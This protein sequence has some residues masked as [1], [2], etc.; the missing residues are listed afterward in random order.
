MRVP[1]GTTCAWGQS[2]QRQPLKDARISLQAFV[3]CLRSHAISCP[4]RFLFREFKGSPKLNNTDLLPQH[5]WH[6]KHYLYWGWY[7]WHQVMNNYIYQ[8][9]TFPSCLLSDLDNYRGSCQTSIN[10]TGKASLCM[11]QTTQAMCS[12]LNR[13]HRIIFPRTILS[14]AYN[15]LSWSNCLESSSV[16]KYCIAVCGKQMN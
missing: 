15:D 9:L 5:H 3:C 16:D 8:E 11:S 13:L 6:L 10:I 4:S 12:T 7:N 2:N 1:S 14:S